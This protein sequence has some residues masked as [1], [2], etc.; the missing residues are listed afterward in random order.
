M[1]I[2][3]I[4]NV[5]IW[6]KGGWNWDRVYQADQNVTSWV[7]GGRNW[8]CVWPSWPKCNQLGPGGH[9]LDCVDCVGPSQPKYNQFRQGGIKLGSC[10]AKSNKMYLPGS[11]RNEIGIVFD[12]NDQNVT[13]W[14]QQGQNLYH[15]CPSQL[16]CDQLGQG[17]TKLGSG[18]TKSTKMWPA[19]SRSTHLGS[20]SPSKPK[21]E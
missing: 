18:L 5:T 12:Q 17:G 20:C 14:V 13:S 16:K 11:R 2:Q 10:L 6:V 1:F 4:Q 21:C 8:Y 9:N 19:G 15:I 3:V 7:Q